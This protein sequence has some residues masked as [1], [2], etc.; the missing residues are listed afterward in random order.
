MS[1]I[2]YSD[3]PETPIQQFYKG[4]TILITGGTGYLGGVI[5]EKLMRSCPNFKK[6][7]LIVRTKKGKSHTERMK[8]QFD[9]LIFSK[10]DPSMFEKVSLILGDC[11]EP[12][13]GLSTT[14]QKVLQEN[15]TIII[16]CAATV[17]FDEEMQ[18]AVSINVTATKDLLILSKKLKNLKA[19]VYVSTAYSNCHLN[20]IEEKFY[21][22]TIDDNKLI[23]LTE[24]L[25]NQQ[26]KN[27]TPLLLDDIP[28]TYVYTKAVAEDIVRRCSKG[29]PVVVVRPSIIIGSLKEPVPGWIDNLYGPSGVIV[30]AMTGIMRIVECNPDKKADLIPA[31]MVA[32]AVIASAWR[33]GSRN[34]EKATAEPLIYNVVSSSQN[35]IKWSQFFKMAN[36]SF[37]STIF[38]IWY[39][40]ILLE[41]NKS[42]VRILKFIC[43]YLPAL[44]I[45]A[46]ANVF[47]KQSGLLKISKKINKFMD[48][49]SYFSL[50]QWEFSDNN[51]QDL[52]HSLDE[53]DKEIFPFNSKDLKWEKYINIYVRGIRQYLIKDDLSTI[54]EGIKRLQRLFWLHCA[55]LTVIALLIGCLTWFIAGFT[56]KYGSTSTTSIYNIYNEI[57]RNEHEIKLKIVMLI[58]LLV[59]ITYVTKK[60]LKIHNKDKKTWIISV[61]GGRFIVHDETI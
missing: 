28:N 39:P 56:I 14:D 3:L 19:F 29:L 41:K 18:Q 5:I 13:L 15:V 32:N 25:N 31:D 42:K 9:H 8:E 37:P 61:L 10:V 16:H 58:I 21:V 30:A 6:I 59:L 27:L 54:P 33:L 45:D 52:W 17:R 36:G 53:R 48:V 4:E 20:K 51:T 49:I 1:K 46:I 26:L 35:P 55:A 60:C 57:S 38:A 40:F 22:S 7:Y 34:E 47:R 11:T 43:H 44:I 24:C 23:T 50:R 2:T 12:M